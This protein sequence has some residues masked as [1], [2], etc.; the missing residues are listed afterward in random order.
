MTNTSEKNLTDNVLID[1][2]HDTGGFDQSDCG[3]ARFES[4]FLDRFVGDRG[5]EIWPGA[6]S[7]RTWAVVVPFCTSMILPLS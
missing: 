5:G 3:V 2:D 7:R 1:C 4:E 6:I